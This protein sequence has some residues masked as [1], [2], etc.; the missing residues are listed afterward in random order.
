L[1]E[2]LVYHPP[3]FTATILAAA[4][5]APLEGAPADGIVPRA[6]YATTN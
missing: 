2:E 4:P 1:R 6:F 5:D 3:D